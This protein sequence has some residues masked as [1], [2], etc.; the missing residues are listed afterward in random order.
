MLGRETTTRCY[1]E[2]LDDATQPLLPYRVSPDPDVL[3]DDVTLKVFSYVPLP[4]MLHQQVV[5]FICTNVTPL[6]AHWDGSLDSFSLLD[7][8][9]P[10]GGSYDVEGRPRPWAPRLPETP[11]PHDGDAPEDSPQ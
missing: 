3:W 7:A 2:R 6:L 1:V 8:L 4:P 9:Q 11:A 10:P 5:A